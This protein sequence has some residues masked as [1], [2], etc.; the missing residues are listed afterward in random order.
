MKLVSTRNTNNKVSFLQ[1]LLSCMPEDGGLYVPYEEQDLRSWILHLDENSSFSN[2]AG[3]LTAALLKE[4]LSPAVSE[5][6]ADSA[7]KDYAPRLRQLDDGLFQIELFH[8][9]TGSHR[10][11]GLLWLAS[12]LEHVLTMQG[13]TATVLT[14]SMGKGGRSVAAAFGNKKR[15]KAIVIYPRGYTKGYDEKFTMQKGGSIYPVEMDG[16]Y[17]EIERLVREVYQDRELVSKYNLTLAN[18][19]NIGRIIPQTFF[20]PFAFTRIKKRS[21][22]NIYYAIP[23]GNYGNITAGLYAWKFRLP[24]S[25]FITDATASLTSDV[26]GFCVCLDSMIPLAERGPA[27]PATPS[28]IE[29]LEQVFSI[30]PALMRSFLFP[31]HVNHERINEIIGTVYH[32]YGIMFDSQTATVYEAALKSNRISQKGAETLVL[33]SKDH[34][35][36]ESE[37]LRAACGEAPIIPER[38]KNM[39]VP[40]KDVHLINGKKEEILQILQ[41][42]TE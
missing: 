3:S 12:T 36:F 32:K 28:N 19:I 6:I 11:F 16:S 31:V 42:I 20:Y 5:R 22:G 33:V 17:A 21:S 40:I 14:P 25:G 35:A 10:D 37:R 8:G 9:P 15:L 13:K 18:T 27:D 23:S 7:F 34:P 41:T 38:L 24:V 29:R 26:H 1:A 2:V 39:D 30:S 4:E